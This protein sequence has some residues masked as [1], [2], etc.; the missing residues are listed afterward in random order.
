MLSPDAK[1]E[2]LRCFLSKPWIWAVFLL[3][4][5]CS[6]GFGRQTLAT[7]R[8][9]LTYQADRDLEEMDRRLGYTPA[10]DV[11]RAYFQAWPATAKP[12]APRLAAKL[13]G[14][15]AEVCNLLNLQPPAGK[16]LHLY[17][18]ADGREVAERYLAF[19]GGK[20]PPLFGYRTLEAFYQSTSR[21]VFLSLT[22]LRCG[23]LAHEMTH[24]V[25]CTALP[26]PP[27]ADL[28]EDWAKQVELRL[29]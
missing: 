11:Y 22:D 28:Q 3:L 29:N 27:P 10:P 26:A 20:Q 14:L 12:V 25:L 6:P 13:D 8:V 23:I 5:F 24:F 4:S 21:T 7:P 9:V 18:L 17:L 1:T 16:P 2:L 19:Q 15:L